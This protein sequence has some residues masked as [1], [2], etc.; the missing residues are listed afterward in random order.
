MDRVHNRLLL[1][2]VIPPARN[3]F[4]CINHNVFLVFVKTRQRCLMEQS[5]IF[6]SQK[7]P[8][9]FGQSAEFFLR[10]YVRNCSLSICANL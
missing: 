2:H 5:R 4:S 8:D 6:V 1:F 10:F 9:P 7:T 3:L